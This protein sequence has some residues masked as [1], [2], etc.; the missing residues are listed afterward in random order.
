MIR[1]AFRVRG[2]AAASRYGISAMKCIQVCAFC[3][4]QAPSGA[5]RC[6]QCG[7]RL[8]GSTL[9]DAY[10]ARRPRCPACGAVVPEGAAYCIRCGKRLPA[11][12]ARNAR[13]E[14]E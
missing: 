4:A 6:P 8:S 10:R 11:P 2:G 1:F 12:A 3:G 13:K 5:R 7:A 14:T 9:Y